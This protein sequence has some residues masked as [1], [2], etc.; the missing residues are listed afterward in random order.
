MLVLA[1]RGH[2][3]TV[4]SPFKL[5]EP[6]RNYTSVVQH[7]ARG[8]HPARDPISAARGAIF[9]ARLRAAKM[10]PRGA[11]WYCVG[12]CWR[13]NNDRRPLKHL[14]SFTFKIF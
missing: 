9:A 14:P 1:K 7:A 5:K 8:P 12:Q 11:F 6:V 3:V 4:V 10:A 2:H 13:A